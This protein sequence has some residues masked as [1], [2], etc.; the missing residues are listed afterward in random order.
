MEQDRANR[1]LGEYKTRVAQIRKFRNRYNSKELAEF[2]F[3]TPELLKLV[4][5]AIDAHPDW[6]DNQIVENV[7]FE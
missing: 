3:I 6:D 2:C 7:E 5:E 1:R 4:L